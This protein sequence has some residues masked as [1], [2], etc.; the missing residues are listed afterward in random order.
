MIKI[1]CERHDGFFW[2]SKSNSCRD[3]SLK[4]FFHIVISGGIKGKGS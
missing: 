4:P 3:I 2:G 1:Y